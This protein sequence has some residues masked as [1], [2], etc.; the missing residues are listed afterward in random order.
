[1]A[2]QKGLELAYTISNETPMVLLGDAIRLWQILTNLLSNAV[3]FT[4]AGEVVVSV[5]SRPPS[6][7]AGAFHP[8][9]E[10]HFAVKD[11]GIGIP[12]DKMDRLFKT[13]G[14]ADVSAT[15]KYGG[16]GHG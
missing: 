9:H 4:S 2:G 13:F 11:S 16:T 3:K 1:M 14:Q 6:D 10:F 8:R 15:R 5:H 12:P 7:G